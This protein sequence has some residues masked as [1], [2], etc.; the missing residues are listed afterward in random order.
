[1]GYRRVCIT[2]CIFSVSARVFELVVTV[3]SQGVTVAFQGVP[4]A[5]FSG[6]LEGWF[7]LHGVSH[8]SCRA[9]G[10]RPKEL[11]R[12]D[13]DPVALPPAQPGV[14]ADPPGREGARER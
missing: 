7:F 3:A 4:E 13:A 12:G 14:A 11:S 1:M 2:V 9:L 10:R 5:T 8:P 6:K